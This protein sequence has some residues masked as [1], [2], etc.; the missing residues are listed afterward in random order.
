MEAWGIVVAAGEGTRFGGRKQFT[1]VLGV[2]LVDRVTAVMTSVC[3]AVVVVLPVDV[4]WDGPPVTVVVAGGRTRSASVRAGLAVIPP[5]ADVVVI[6]DAAHPLAEPAPF[7]AVIDAV[8]A[9]ADATAPALPLD[10]PIKR[11]RDHDVVTETILRDDVRMIQTP[12][13]FRADALRAAHAD[14][15]EAVEDTALIEGRGGTVVLFPGSI[16]NLHVTAFEHLDLVAR[17]AGE[18]WAVPLLPKRCAG[19]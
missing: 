13:G 15:P 12:H 11:V 2:R 10:E 5:A 1:E 7:R 17:L 9:G 4:R 3:D 6:H 14:Q 16:R 8:R 18:E 19:R